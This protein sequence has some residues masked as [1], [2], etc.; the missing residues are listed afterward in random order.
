MEN[1]KH[2][3]HHSTTFRESN[4]GDYLPPCT[5][6][7][8]AEYIKEVE[9]VQVTPL[10][11]TVAIACNIFKLIEASLSCGLDTDTIQ[12]VAG[13]IIHCIIHMCMVMDAKLALYIPTRATTEDGWSKSKLLQNLARA[14]IT[15]TSDSLTLICRPWIDVKAS[16]EL[17]SDILILV[18]GVMRVAEVRDIHQLLIRNL[19]RTGRHETLLMQ[20]SAL[21]AMLPRLKIQMEITSIYP[22]L[23]R[24][25]A[26]APPLF[27]NLLNKAYVAT[28]GQYLLLGDVVLKVQRY[29]ATKLITMSLEE[30]ETNAATALGHSSERLDFEDKRMLIRPILKYLV[31]V[32][33][34]EH[35][36]FKQNARAELIRRD[37]ENKR[38]LSIPVSMPTAVVTKETQVSQESIPSVAQTVTLEDTDEEKVDDPGYMPPPQVQPMDSAIWKGWN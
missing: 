29:L 36:E 4:E 12:V 23:Y 1:L 5:F 30:V 32:S 19:E 35:W 25:N 9:V 38:K 10:M 8:Y 15:L 31:K 18:H 22:Y 11:L 17:R 6:S 28:D 27:L 7:Y 20:R 37:Q 26:S 21:M 14:A 24:V 3:K 33:Y 34:R 13:D 16:E 2:K